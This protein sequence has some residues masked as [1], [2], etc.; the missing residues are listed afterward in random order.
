[1]KQLAVRGVE[2][3]LLTTM[4]PAQRGILSTVFRLGV[5]TFGPPQARPVGALERAGL[6]S[7]QRWLQ[8]TDRTMTTV[9]PAL[10]FK[11]P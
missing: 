10:Q 9:R 7:V 2:P 8:G 3:Q 5:A 4:T 6:V 1:L 11:G